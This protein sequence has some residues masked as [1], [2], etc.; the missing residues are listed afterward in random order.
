MARGKFKVGFC[1]SGNGY[2]ARAA[3]IQ[4]ER[5]EIEPVLVVGERSTSPELEAFCDRQAV[6]FERVLET[7]RSAFDER[8]ADLCI[9]ADL[10]LLM[11]VFNKILNA[12]LVS[13]YENRIVNMHPALLPAF[14]GYRGFRD[15]VQSDA[16]F[17]GMSLQELVYEMDEG[18]IIAQTIVGKRWGEDEASVGRRLYGPLRLMFL[19]VI[20]W[21]VEGRVR[22]EEGH[23]N[24]EGAVYGEFP[25]SPSIEMSFPE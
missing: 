21:Y 22:K 23:I 17:V 4:R 1:C 19:Q 8:I 6:P 3:I 10:D 14:A 7:D 18:P 24:I 5:L 25:T 16:R 11:V 2:L 13:H 20:R 9:G 15:S 12:R